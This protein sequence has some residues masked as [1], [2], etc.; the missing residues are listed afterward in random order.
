MYDGVGGCVE[1]EMMSKRLD[2]TEKEFESLTMKLN[3]LKIKKSQFQEQICD[4]KIQ[5]CQSIME[6]NRYIAYTSMILFALVI[7]WAM[8]VVKY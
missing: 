1:C 8:F 6:N 4:L 5:L 7:S 3:K 2:A